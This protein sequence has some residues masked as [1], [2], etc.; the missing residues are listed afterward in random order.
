MWN[1]RKILLELKRNLSK[2]EWK[3]G[4]LNFALA[5]ESLKD[6]IKNH[7]I[8]IEEE[9]RWQHQKLI[10]RKLKFNFAPVAIHFRA[11]IDKIL[12][13]SILDTS[14]TDFPD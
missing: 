10:F 7:K 13:K 8:L 14:G 6:E 9:K 4:K 3:L 5:C 1:L 12:K 11:E 2:D